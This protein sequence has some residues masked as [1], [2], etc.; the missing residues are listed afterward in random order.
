[1][2]FTLGKL[3]AIGC[4]DVYLI[5]RL[6]TCGSLC[7]ADGSSRT[8]RPRLSSLPSGLGTLRKAS[9]SPIDGTNS[10][11]NGFNFVSSTISCGWYLNK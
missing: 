10:G 2:N 9:I 1:M 11:I 6:S 8:I 4:F 3:V 7:F 5:W